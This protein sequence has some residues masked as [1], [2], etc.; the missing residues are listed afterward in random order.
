MDIRIKWRD[1]CNKW[2]DFPIEDIVNHSR[3][4]V[5]DLFSRPIPIL[6]KQ[7]DTY[8]SND[9][10]IRQAYHKRGDK[11]IAMDKIERNEGKLSEV[12]FL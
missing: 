10:A 11:V 3:N 5:I 9:K 8:I 4:H 12:G 2:I 6:I 7:D 1:S